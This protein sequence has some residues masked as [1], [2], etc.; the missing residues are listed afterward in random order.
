L[1]KTEFTS[2]KLNLTLALCA[3]LISVASFYA[4]Y[5]QANAAE[6]Q[7]KAMTLPLLQFS[8]GNYDSEENLSAISFTL[9][10]AGV[11]PALIKSVKFVHNE[12]SYDSRLAFFRACCEKEYNHYIKTISEKTNLKEGGFYS[13]PLVNSILPGQDEVVF[14]KMYKHVSEQGFWNIINKE[15]FNLKM[16]LCY[17][18]LLND[19]YL[20]ERNGIVEEV[21]ACPVEPR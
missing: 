3:V 13:S 18:S 11:G 16:K 12:T 8:S 21:D 19:C 20:S 17:C 14:F 2:E 1:S 7:V 10:N 5:I 4:T 9:K 6:K 15:R